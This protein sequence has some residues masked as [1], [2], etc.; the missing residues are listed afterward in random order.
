MLDWKTIA[1]MYQMGLMTTPED[2]MRIF[3][4]VA[5]DDQWESM[6]Q[7]SKSVETGDIFEE[8]L[9]VQM[10]AN[11]LHYVPKDDWFVHSTWLNEIYDDLKY[12]YF[13][14]HKEEICEEKDWDIDEINDILYECDYIE[15]S[16]H[17][18]VYNY[19]EEILNDYDDED[20]DDDGDEDEDHHN[21]NEWFEKLRDIHW[22]DLCKGNEYTTGY[23]LNQMLIINRDWF[24]NGL[25]NVGYEICR[26]FDDQ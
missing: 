2:C 18:D 5:Q 22:L 16:Y 11:I 10:V 15:E 25:H 9:F 6:R 1:N 14:Q 8:W 3:S 13:I 4:L 17:C 21:I 24:L 23:Y 20:R 7:F 19:I 26:S 12:A